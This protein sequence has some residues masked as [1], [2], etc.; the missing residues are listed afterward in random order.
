MNLDNP[1]NKDFQE[2]LDD[3]DGH[4]RCSQWELGFIRKLINQGLAH[5]LTEKQQRSLRKIYRERIMKQIPAG[6]GR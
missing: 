3:L 2:M 5:R 4:H 1:S 6:R